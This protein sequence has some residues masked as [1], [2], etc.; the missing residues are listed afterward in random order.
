VVELGLS[1]E[2]IS[3]KTFSGF[4]VLTCHRKWEIKHVVVANIVVRPK[5]VVTFELLYRRDGDKGCHFV[6]KFIFLIQVGLLSSKRCEHSRTDFLSDFSVSFRFFLLRPADSFIFSSF[7]SASDFC[8][9]LSKI[10]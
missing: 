1:A 4:F 10:A 6:L 5:Y 3:V 9:I 2:R 8:L 7:F